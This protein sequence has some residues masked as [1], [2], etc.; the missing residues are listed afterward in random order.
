MNASK[1]W[2]GTSQGA[3]A[4]FGRSD[5]HGAKDGS[6]HIRFYRAPRLARLGSLAKQTR[7]GGQ[8]ATEDG[9]P[10]THSGSADFLPLY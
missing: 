9:D 5:G 1:A 6:V 7:S 2:D 4:C 3:N 8:S 10:Y